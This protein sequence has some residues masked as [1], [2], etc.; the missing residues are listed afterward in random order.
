MRRIRFAADYFAWPLWDVDEGSNLQPDALPLSAALCNRLRA[1]ADEFDATLDLEDPTGSDFPS[2]ESRQEFL[3]LGEELA[4]AVAAELGD[5]Y[6]V[7]F[8]SDR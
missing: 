7:R 8:G 1:W 3:R 6:A 4:R 2:E 5:G